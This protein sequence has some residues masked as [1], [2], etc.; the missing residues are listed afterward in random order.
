MIGDLGLWLP[1]CAVIV[2]TP[3]LFRVQPSVL[4]IVVNLHHL[5]RRSRPTYLS[6]GVCLSPSFA[7]SQVSYKTEYSTASFVA[8]YISRMQIINGAF[9][10]VDCDCTAVL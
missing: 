4:Q 6:H 5:T 3:R 7:V 8:S 10:R 2:I 1:D 9:Y